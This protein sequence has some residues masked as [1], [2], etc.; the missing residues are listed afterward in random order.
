VRLTWGNAEERV[1]RR[2]ARGIRMTAV[3][4]RGIRMTAVAITV[5]CSKAEPPPP[6][7][8]QAAAPAPVAAA[9]GDSACPQTGLWAECSLLYRLERAGLMAHV[10][11]AAQ[12]EDKTLTGRVLMLKIGR[13]A[14]L[15]LHIYA[16]S[17]MRAAAAKTLDGASYVGA[18]TP[19]TAKREKTLI[20]SVNVIGLLTSINAHQRE[21]V[22]DALTAGPPQPQQAQ[23]LKPVTSK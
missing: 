6:P 5:A 18:T 2:A 7:N 20:E 10:D 22:S 4:S 1:L 12:P 21:R 19:Q 14:Q 13:S 3:C 17:T 8:T 23:R 15:E 16:D 11:S 9:P